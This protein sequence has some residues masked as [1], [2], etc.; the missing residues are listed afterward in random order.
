[1]VMAGS[2]VHQASIRLREQIV[3]LAAAHFEASPADITLEDGA[4]IVRGVPDRRCSLRQIAAL[5]AAPLEAE[6]RHET[7]RAVGSFGVH[8]SVV[9]VDVTTGQVQPE[10]HFVL[11]DV[12]RAINPTIVEAQLVG[13]V[14]QGLGHATMEELVYDPSGQLLTGTFM[15]YA[16]PTASRTPAVEVMVQEAAAPSNPLGVKGAGEAGTSGVGAAVANA[17]ANAVG[18]AAARHLPLTA[19]RVRAALRAT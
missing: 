2:A 9:G 10:T 4:A 12:G 5:A 1:M 17:V 14:V 8:L 6:W 7:T 11:C 19:P 18:A 3:A 16:M 15:D 13:A